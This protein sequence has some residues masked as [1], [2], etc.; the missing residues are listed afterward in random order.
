MFKLVQN[1]F[2]IIWWLSLSS[3]SLAMLCFK[4]VVCKAC[5]Y[6]PMS[7]CYKMYYFNAFNAKYS[8]KLKLCREV[9]NFHLKNFNQLKIFEALL[10]HMWTCLKSFCLCHILWEC[11]SSWFSAYLF[12]LLSVYYHSFLDKIVDWLLLF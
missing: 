4:S 10:A 7:P 2:C 9:P 11:K 8:R 5:R 3:S 12:S 1:R 6:L